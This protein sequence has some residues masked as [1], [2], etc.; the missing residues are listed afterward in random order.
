MA[1]N[2]NGYPAVKTNLP[3]VVVRRIR[4]MLEAG[5]R[6]ITQV[7]KACGVGTAAVKRL[8]ENDPELKALHEAAYEATMEEVEDAGIEICTNPEINPIARV[9]MI[10]T[11]LK[12]R[13]SKVYNQALSDVTDTSGVQN[14]RRIVIA[15]VLPVV[16]VD[17]NGIP[18]DTPKTKEKQGE[19]INV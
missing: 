3:P 1:I 14:I 19:V 2:K 11:F 18:I 5:T 7:A 10:E 8:I 9:K 15:P 4:D 12:G 13:R 17:S 16:Q 6:H